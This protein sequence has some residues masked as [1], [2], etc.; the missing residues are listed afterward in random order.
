MKVF[1]LFTTPPGSDRRVTELVRETFHTGFPTADWEIFNNDQNEQKLHKWIQ[2]LLDREKD[3]DQ[4]IVFLDGDIIFWNS[5]ENFNP[6]HVL[7]GFWQPP[8]INDWS[9]CFYM[10]RLHT[11]LLFIRSVKELHARIEE[12]KPWKNPPSR[13]LPTIPQ[14]L[15]SPEQGYIYTKPI[16]WDVAAKLFHAIGGQKFSPTELDKY[17]HINSASNYETMIDRI[18]DEQHK[19]GFRHVHELAKMQKEKLRGLWRETLTYYN[20][21]HITL[22]D[23]LYPHTSQ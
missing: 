20:Q 13:E 3:N 12:A 17:D 10:Q 4:P 5:F 15:I 1:T 22:H 11:S 23:Y 14:D 2:F 7:S 16:Y 8:H 6:S 19:A 21:R 18:P 9:G